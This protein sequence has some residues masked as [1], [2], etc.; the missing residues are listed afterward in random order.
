M[1]ACGLDDVVRFLPCSACATLRVTRVSS[2]CIWCG[3]GGDGGG[4]CMTAC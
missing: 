1:C 2:A 3:G 4:E